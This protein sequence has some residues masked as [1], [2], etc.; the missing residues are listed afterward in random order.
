MLLISF[1]THH[2]F[3]FF[4]VFTSFLLLLPLPTMSCFCV[5]GAGFLV[6]LW[7]SSNHPCLF[8]SPLPGKLIFWSDVGE[9]Q[10]LDESISPLPFYPSQRIC[11]VRYEPPPVSPAQAYIV[12][13]LGHARMLQLPARQARSACSVPL[14]EIN[15]IFYNPSWLPFH[16]SVSE[17]WVLPITQMPPQ[18][19]FLWFHQFSKINLCILQSI[20]SIVFIPIKPFLLLTSWVYQNA[21]IFLPPGSEKMLSHVISVFCHG[22]PLLHR[23]HLWFLLFDR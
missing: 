2:S 22:C 12:W 23:T 10:L 14:V 9:N 7:N 19:H 5:C 13:V 16:L 8:L 20:L 4:V 3:S 11:Q 18:M 6:P 15:W 1:F 17:L 21:L